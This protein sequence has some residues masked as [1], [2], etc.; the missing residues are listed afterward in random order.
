M[1]LLFKAPNDPSAAVELLSTPGVPRVLAED[2]VHLVMKLMTSHPPLV[3]AVVAGILHDDFQDLIDTTPDDLSDKYVEVV[4]A[5]STAALTVL[6]VMKAESE[7]E[8][9]PTDRDLL[10]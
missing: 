8:E 1:S 6:A 2:A 5:A 7:K 4:N 10:N 3:L 9:D